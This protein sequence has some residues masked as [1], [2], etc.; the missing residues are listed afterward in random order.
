MINPEMLII[1]SKDGH[2]PRVTELILIYEEIMENHPRYECGT[3]E[4]AESIKIFYNTYISAK[5]G[6]VNMIQDF[7]MKIGHMNVD[8]V[9]DAMAHSD[10]RLQ[11][12]KYMT[13]GMGDSGACHP[14]DNIALRWLAEEY[15]IGYDM[16]STIMGAREVQA[17]NM[18]LF[19]VDQ[20]KAR[21]LP[22][23]IHGKAYKPDIEY[24]IGSYSTLIGHYVIEAGAVVKYLDPLADDQTDVVETLDS[25]AV[26]LL[27]HNRK[28][29]YG[30]VTE[31]SGSDLNDN[32]YTDIPES[33]IIVD[34][35]RKMDTN[36]DKYTVVY[37]GDTRNI[38]G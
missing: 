25:P 4:E 19:L 28:I 34:P 6:I 31:H 23:V 21:N 14:R 38:E 16:F 29:T 17:K 18:A 8:V 33:S 20:A 26:V 35:W 27:A 2:D 7:A 30:Y 11:S 9:T 13:A 36:S 1:G 3:W 22:V 12:P 24:C 10:I 32:F 37:Y 5:I 15:G